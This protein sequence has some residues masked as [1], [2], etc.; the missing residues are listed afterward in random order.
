IQ[1]L[2]ARPQHAEQRATDC[3]RAGYEMRTNKS[4]LR[5]HYIRVY[6]IKYLPSTI[7]ISITGR[8]SEV[9]IADSVLLKGFNNF[10]LISLSYSFRPQES[11]GG[12]F[13]RQFG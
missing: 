4:G 7:I 2:L 6:E 5:P 12:S 10:P 13:L 8:T 1:Q 3:M 11:G 9:K